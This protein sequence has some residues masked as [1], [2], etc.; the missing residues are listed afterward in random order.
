MEGLKG[1]NSS[2]EDATR[3]SDYRKEK[4]PVENSE[5]SRLAVAD[6]EHQGTDTS[7]L[8]HAISATKFLQ[9]AV[10]N[11]GN[12]Q[13]TV[14]GL[15]IES[16]LEILQ[17]V[18]GSQ[19]RRNRPEEDGPPFRTILAPGKITRDL[20]VPPIDKVMACLRMAQGAYASTPC[21]RS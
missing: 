1:I 5:L 4:Y 2:S 8:S 14:I 20:P 15:E 6:S 18:A 9:E 3:P 17:A 19:G 10:R 7:L 11:D 12:E 13:A 16:A 21:S